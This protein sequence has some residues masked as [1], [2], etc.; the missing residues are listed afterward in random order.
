M[1]SHLDL[2]KQTWALLDR[3]SKVG[4]QVVIGED[5]LTLAAVVAV[6]R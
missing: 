5:E 4:D 1:S 3:F 6:S 2:L